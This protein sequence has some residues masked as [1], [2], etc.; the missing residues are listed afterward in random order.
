M[1]EIG[2]ARQW[3]ISFFPLSPTT[4]ARDAFSMRQLPEFQKKLEPKAC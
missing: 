4:T 3:L 2:L 1:M